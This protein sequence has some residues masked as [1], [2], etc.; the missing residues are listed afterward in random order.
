MGLFDDMSQFLEQRLDDFLKRHPYLEL[1][2]LEEQLREQAVKTQQLIQSLQAKE[3]QLQNSVLLIA[4]EIKRW[5]ERIAKAERAGR[6]DLVKPA[7][8]REA[9]LLRQ[10]NQMWGQLASVKQH[11][12]QAQQLYQQTQ[13]KHQE[14]QRKIAQMPRSAHT[15]ASGWEN[16]ASYTNSD[17]LDPVEAQFRE[18]EIAQDLQNLKRDL[19]Q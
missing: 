3:Q 8:E 15:P 7:R 18:W 14:I 9:A 17:P 16:P 12:T 13:H 10:G 19:E 4:A 1:Q 5:H 6:F 11:L 2:A